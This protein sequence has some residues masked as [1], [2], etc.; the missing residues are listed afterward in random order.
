[1]MPARLFRTLGNGRYAKVSEWRNEMR[2]DLR[3]YELKNQKEIPT[4][5]E[6]V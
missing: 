5:K 3:E 4:K 1:M 6:L 2:V